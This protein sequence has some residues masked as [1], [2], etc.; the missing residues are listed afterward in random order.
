[1]VYTF[2][3]SIFLSVSYTF[4]IISFI[5]FSKLKLLY[6]KVLF[7]VFNF[8]VFQFTVIIDTLL[9]LYFQF[10]SMV[11]DVIL[12]SSLKEVIETIELELFVV[13]FHDQE[14]FLLSW[15]FSFIYY[16]NKRGA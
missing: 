14:V 13:I 2:F 9:F 11:D 12:S 1:M 8:V 6:E 7:S 3:Q 4:M 5:L 10:I 15:V 16:G